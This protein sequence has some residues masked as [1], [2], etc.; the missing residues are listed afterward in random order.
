MEGVL[1]MDQQERDG[2]LSNSCRYRDLDSGPK[3][4]GLKSPLS[5]TR[6][7][8]PVSPHH[9][10]FFRG[11]GCNVWSPDKCLPLP[12]GVMSSTP[13]LRMIIGGKKGG[14]ERA[15]EGLR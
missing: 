3:Q 2:R 15:E 14:G 9:L 12:P 10:S 5:P 7:P 1:L 13:A 8:A 4:A 11:P 6:Q